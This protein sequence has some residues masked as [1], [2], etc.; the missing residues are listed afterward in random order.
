MK[1][2]S[3][4]HRS[5]SRNNKDKKSPQQ[6]QPNQFDQNQRDQQEELLGITQQL[7]GYANVKMIPAFRYR[8]KEKN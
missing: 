8:T 2:S 3:W 6:Q 4:F 7:I 1:L 5:V